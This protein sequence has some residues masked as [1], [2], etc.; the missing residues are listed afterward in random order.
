MKPLL[1]R[2]G[3]AALLTAATC[4]L[5]PGLAQT[6]P[7]AGAAAPTTTTNVTANITERMTWW[8][9][10]GIV[11]I[12]VG[13]PGGSI[14]VTYR[15]MMRRQD[16]STVAQRDQADLAAITARDDSYKQL[17][18]LFTSTVRDSSAAIADAAAAKARLDSVE[19]RQKERED[20]E[21]DLIA[22][23]ASLEARHTSLN[24]HVNTCVGGQPCPLAARRLA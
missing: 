8:Q 20:R 13:V 23:M 24:E 21:R 16:N 11:V 17:L 1:I 5:S 2:Q 3:V 22:R 15:V 14:Y 10:V 19:Q 18:D 6:L 4:A 12:V 9:V 7:T